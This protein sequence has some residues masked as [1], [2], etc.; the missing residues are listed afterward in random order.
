[1]NLLPSIDHELRIHEHSQLFLLYIPTEMMCG[2]KETFPNITEI[3]SWS[4]DSEIVAFNAHNIED[5][6]RVGRLVS[7]FFPAGK[8][9]GQF[10]PKLIEKILLSALDQ[11]LPLPDESWTGSQFPSA[12]KVVRSVILE[13]LYERR[14]PSLEVLA[15]KVG[16]NNRVLQTVFK[17]YCSTTM[18]D[19]YQNARMEAIYR[20][21]YDR[22]RSLQEIADS[23]NYED[24]STFSAA[25]KRKW[26]R[27]PRELRNYLFSSPIKSKSYTANNHLPS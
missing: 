12:I 1:M 9:T 22:N 19:F 13:H 25:I 8:V 3:L 11:L 27:S 2:Y 6:G 10:G 15:R 23:F 21:L 20:A 5:D 17:Q 24:Y 4:S 14:P 16:L 7:E 26:G 18:L